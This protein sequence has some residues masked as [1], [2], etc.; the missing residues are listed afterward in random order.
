MDSAPDRIP[1]GRIRLTYDDYVGLP[2]DGKRYEILDGELFVTLAPSTR[3]QQVS[4]QLGVI[5]FRHVRGAR[6]G[7]VLQAPV[8]VIFDGSTVA[9]PDIVF[10]AASRDAIVTERAIEGAPDLV[11]EILSPSTLRQDRTTKAA[12]YAR[13]GV[14]HYWIVDPGER[15]I[16][17]YER[18]ADSSRLVS[19]EAGDATIRPGLCPGLEIHLSEVWE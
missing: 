10:V 8:D 18:E 3:H 19:K 16:E 9:Q 4:I 14:A 11:I 2:N 17:C 1:P 15:T 6:L 13:F 5:L 12:L 7:R